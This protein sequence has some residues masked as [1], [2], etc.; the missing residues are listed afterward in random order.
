MT[1][2]RPDAEFGAIAVRDECLLMVRRGRQPGIGLWSVPGGHV[3][4]GESVVSAVVRELAEETGVDGV[5]GPLMGWIERTD[6]DYHHVIL[7]FEVTVLSDD[8]PVAGDDA[9]EAVWVPLGEI[10]GLD[11]VDGLAA[12]LVEHGVTPPLTLL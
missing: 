1:S 2:G 9:A 12:F 5:C 3:E 6:I 7:D 4:A 10:G 11:L 8:W